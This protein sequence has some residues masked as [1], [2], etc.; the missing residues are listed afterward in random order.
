V[1]AG[2]EKI[3]RHLVKA[4]DC[5]ERPGNEVQFILDDQ[6]G[7]VETVAVVEAAALTQFR[8][9]E[10]AKLRIGAVHIPE[11]GAARS[12]PGQRGKLVY[13]GN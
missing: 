11:E 13:G 4:G 12:D 3:N 8:R 9:A 1:L 10:E 2:G 6:V 5:T 7:R